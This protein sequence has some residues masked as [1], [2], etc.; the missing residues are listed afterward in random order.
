ML[1]L[2]VP[3]L[4][5]PAASSATPDYERISTGLKALVDISTGLNGWALLILAGTLAVMLSTSYR[6][7]PFPYRLIFLVV[8]PPLWYLVRVLERG[9]HVQSTYVAMLL[10][11]RV[12]Q[13]AR[14]HL[15]EAN[16]ALADQVR[17]FEIAVVLIAV[18]L[19]LYLMWW[20]FLDRPQ[21][22]LELQE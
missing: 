11:P 4:S 3:A 18:W 17:F 21:Q 19:A 13:I 10:R 12:D 7:P 8:L 15:A 22:P 6:K 9:N 1:S 2:L 16:T 14:D 20:I 5:E